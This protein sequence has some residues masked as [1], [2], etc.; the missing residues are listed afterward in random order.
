MAIEAALER[1]VV[2]LGLALVAVL[3]IG[4]F[5]TWR[6]VSYVD[7]PCRGRLAAA[8]ARELSGEPRVPARELEIVNDAYVTKEGFVRSR[9]TFVA[10]KPADGVRACNTVPFTPA[11]GTDTSM[12][13]VEYDPRATLYAVVDTAEPRAD[14]QPAVPLAVRRFDHVGRVFDA[15]RVVDRYNVSMLVFL[16]ALGA[17][18]LGALRLGQ[19]RPYAKRMHRWRPGTLR[20]DGVVESETGV[21]LGRVDPSSKLPPGDVIVDP[22]AFE[23]RDVY[24][25]VPILTRKTVGAGSH[26]RWTAGTLRQLR[27]ARSLAALTA[28]TTAAALV[29]RLLA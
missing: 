29:A 4:S 10:V 6:F 3:A 22:A 5:T 24:R 26:E 21:T 27:D 8:D 13:R 11:H 12:Y 1:T 7:V 28:L 15:T 2:Q 17:L 9:G 23:D 16:V 20:E 25:E 18:G 14:G 19:A